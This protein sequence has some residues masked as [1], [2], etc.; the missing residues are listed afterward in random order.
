MG[1]A[2]LIINEAERII[3]EAGLEKFRLQDIADSIGIQFPSLY[4]HFRGKQEILLCIVERSVD[5]LSHQFADAE[6]APPEKLLKIGV[7]R[8]VE[9]FAENIAQ[10]RLLLLDFSMAAGMPEFNRIAGK[11]GE[12]LRE[13][14]P[15]QPMFMRLTRILQYGEECGV[16]KSVN[17]HIFFI[18]IF[19]IILVRLALSRPYPN[20]KTNPEAYRTLVANLQM[21]MTEVA[22]AMLEPEC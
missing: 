16:F 7:E 20:H 19:G 12:F 3:G 11:P 8:L 13:E 5:A 9:H 22:T 2:E 18:N 21:Q 4:T 10:V 14:S 17:P 1:T 6:S 15:L